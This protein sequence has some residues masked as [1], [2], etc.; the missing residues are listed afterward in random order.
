MQNADYHIGRAAGKRNR[1]GTMDKKIA[2][3]EKE[4]MVKKE[5][6]AVENVTA[7]QEEAKKEAAPEIILQYRGYEAN[8]DAVV[9]QVKAHYRAKGHAQEAVE[10]LQV[11]IKPEDFTAYYVLN[12]RVSEIGRAH[13]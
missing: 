4:V 10:S 9:E 3:T 8:I 11:Y 12:D 7:V 13:V 2:T 1:E 6:E 5:A